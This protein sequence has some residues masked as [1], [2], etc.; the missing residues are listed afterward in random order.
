MKTIKNFVTIAAIVVVGNVG[1]ISAQEIKD[2]ENRVIV[3]RE[4][5]KAIPFGKE[6]SLLVENFKT[7]E[8]GSDESPSKIDNS[9]LPGWEIKNVYSVGGKIY[10]PSSESKIT[11]PEFPKLRA[12]ENVWFRFKAKSEKPNGKLFIKIEGTGKDREFT[13]GDVTIS[14]PVK[15]KWDEYYSFFYDGTV[16]SKI[17]IYLGNGSSPVYIDDI[18]IF[19][20]DQYVS[21]PKMLPHS[22]YNGKSFIAH[23][24]KPDG[25]VGYRINV[26]TVDSRFTDDDDIYPISNIKDYLVK[27]RFTNN[28]FFLVEDI[29]PNKSYYYTVT[30]YNDTAY[31]ILSKRIGVVDVVSPKI[32][33]ASV[34][35]E[36]IDVKWSPVE[37]AN[38]Y[39]YSVLRKK[40]FDKDEEV[41]VSEEDMEN[42]YILDPV[43]REEHEDYLVRYTTEEL[44][45]NYTYYFKR[46]GENYFDVFYDGWKSTY[47]T[48]YKEGYLGLNNSEFIEK[49][50]GE[51]AKVISPELD[52]SKD[53]GRF[54]LSVKLQSANALSETNSRTTFRAQARFILKNYNESTCRYEISEI[55]YAKDVE[56]YWKTFE[57]DFSNGTSKS[58]VE[59][60]AIDSIGINLYVDDIKITQYYKAGDT[61]YL[62]KHGTLARSNRVILSVH[63]TVS[64]TAEYIQRIS[65]IRVVKAAE[66]YLIGKEIV[67]SNSCEASAGTVTNSIDN[68][69]QPEFSVEVKNNTVYISNTGTYKVS[70]F[71]LDGK[72][73]YS[74]ADKNSH[75][76][77]LPSNTYIIHVGNKSMKLVF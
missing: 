25:A 31:S 4:I 75:C 6:S 12:G 1:T 71:T 46:H 5:G 62:L 7:L 24:T 21:T 36:Q 56:D 40:V 35:N 48:V 23:W 54:C 18:E 57:V 26:F 30:A 44:L 59:I 72:S 50:T 19:T 60:E 37:G 20:V 67:I 49:Q 77:N 74:G 29:D 16:D 8:T 70:V 17:S 41:V 47:S 55:I 10:L 11:T 28:N 39:E 45:D 61:A 9:D 73:V 15:D 14:T 65:S 53:D 3:N 51:I 64:D 43:S 27:D 22:N 63:D 68:L 58:I 38:A 2:Y 13:K 34:N 66:R 32:E 76:I 42:Q 33:E 69:Q 52:L